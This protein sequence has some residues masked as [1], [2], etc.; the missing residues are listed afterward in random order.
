MTEGIAEEI[1]RT[2]T[3]LRLK[4][5]Y[6]DMGLEDLAKDPKGITRQDLKIWKDHI[7]ETRKTLADM[8]DKI[9]D[10]GVALN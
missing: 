6:A 5:V 8:Y 3:D 7:R 9:M 4:A 2:I 10:L 1:G